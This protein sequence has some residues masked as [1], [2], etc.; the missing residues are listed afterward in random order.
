MSS[1]VRTSPARLL[2]GLAAAFALAAASLLVT[3]SPAAA[4]DEL[5]G[6]DPQTGATVDALPAEL[7]LTYSANIAPDAGASEVQ[8]TD[9][10]GT[11]LQDGAPVVQDNVLTQT[12]TGE[13]S[14]AVTVLWKVVSSDGHPISGEFTFTVAGAPTPT[15]T[16]TTEPTQTSEPSEPAE[17]TPAETAVPVPGD[18]AGASSPV[19]WPWIVGGIVVLAIAAGVAYLVASRARRQRELDAARDGASEAA[20][21]GTE[22]PAAH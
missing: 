16:A 21:R 3:A 14:G 6:S 4:H 20:R 7:T 12:L 1:R 9:A 8:V 15:P 18:D 2:A 22:P 11:A 13:A 17:P 10:A 19:V 5:I